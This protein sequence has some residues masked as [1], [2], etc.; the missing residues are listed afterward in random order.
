MINISNN[1]TAWSRR[2]QALDKLGKY[3]EAV[4]SFDKCKQTTKI[5]KILMHGIIKGNLY[6]FANMRRQ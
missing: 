4:K 2:G 3:D 1:E 6:V 5:L